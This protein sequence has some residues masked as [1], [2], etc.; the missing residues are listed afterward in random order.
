MAEYDLMPKLV[1]HLDRHLIFPLLEFADN[2]IAEDDDVK[3]REITQAK[4]ELL[5]TT[6]MTDFIGN[7]KA[8]LE[9]LDEV[10]AEF[11]D[12]RQ[13]VLSRLEQFEDE[14]KTLTDLLGEEEVVNNLRSDKVANLEFLK[15]EH[16]VCY[17]HTGP[18]NMGVIY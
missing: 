6:N 14:T 18:R 4:Y 13:K 2:Q 9:G 16:Q 17:I 3:A 11:D 5:K 15:K 8:Q 12:K 10:P 7:L 1:A